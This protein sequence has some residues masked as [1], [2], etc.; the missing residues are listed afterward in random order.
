M[1][2]LYYLISF[3]LVINIIVIVHEYGHF[4]AA[5]QVGV[6]ISKFSVGMG[7]EIVGF[8][9][10]H[11]TR[12]SLSLLP[13]GGFV[14]MLGDGDI[15][16]AT[17]D[18]SV[19][20]LA[21]EERKLAISS[22][23]NWEK[24]WVAFCGPFFN[25]IYAFVVIIGMGL[26][27]GI[28]TYEP[29]I[30]SVQ[31]NSPAAK[32]G[33][34]AGDRVL[35]VNGHEI[36][37]YRDIVINTIEDETG[38]LDFLVERNGAQQN[39]I[40]APEIK[41]TKSLIRTKKTKFVGIRSGS[42]IFEKKSFVDAVVRA[43]QECVYSTKEMGHVFAQLFAGKKSLDDFGG[44]VRMASVAGDLSKDGNF[45]MLIMFTVTLSLNLGFINLFPLPVLDG[46]R[47]L[48]CFIEQV[49]R[50]KLN[51]KI[52]EYIMI[53]CACLLILLMLATTVN[54]ILRLEAVE[55][56]ISSIVR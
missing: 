39:I 48:L 1:S 31:E 18:E 25:Y 14:M 20:S 33:L 6:K 53:V 55:K 40:L 30:G 21:E 26:F 56:F 16:S 52:Q 51:E 3:F 29:V 9:D 13:V 27:Y 4:L 12:W 44:I 5:K 38:K 41:E 45:A 54:D 15:A 11:G 7:P 24:I 47:I 10:K 50:R 32:A 34:L 8:T 35:S 46:G 36:R 23:T 43:F 22:K 2:I 49:T 28:P 17:E 42:P 37:K 19:K